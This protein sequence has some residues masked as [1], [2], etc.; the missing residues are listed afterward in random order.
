MNDK[1]FLHWIH[2]R[3]E[4][5]H[6]ES[7]YVD[8]MIRLRN[9]AESLPPQNETKYHVH[10]KTIEQLE[11]VY[12]KEYEQELESCENWIKFCKIHGDAYG[13]NF[14]QGL[15]HGHIF[16]NIKMGQLLRI[17]KKEAPNVWLWIHIPHRQRLKN[18]SPTIQ[19]TSHENL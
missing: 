3:L 8:Y 16:N 12:D 10:P 19:T 14:H 15:Q 9:I 17:L 7:H 2:D 1:E 6:N 18:Y 4:N 5:K 13:V 11:R